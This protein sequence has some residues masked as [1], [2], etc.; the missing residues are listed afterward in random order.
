MKFSRNDYC[1]CGSGKKYKN[2]HWGQEVPVMSKKETLPAL[3]LDLD[4]LDPAKVDVMAPGYWEKLSKQLPPGMRKEFGPMIRQVKQYAEV[5]SQRVRIEAAAKILD[6]H[7][8]EYDLLTKDPSKLFRRAEDLFSEDRFAAMRF[9]AA[10]VQRAF[11][12]VGFPPSGPMEKEFTR[13]VDKAIRFLLDESRRDDL[14]QQLLRMLPDYTD[15]GRYLDGWLIQHNAQFVAEMSNGVV[16]P[17]LLVMFMYGMREW[18]E[19]RDREQEALFKEM[20]LDR[21]EIRRLG[22]EGLEARLRGLMDKPEK[23]AALKQF[24]AKHPELQAMTQAQCF[25]AEKAAVALLERDDAQRLCLSPDEVEPWLKVFERRVEAAPEGL[26]ALTATQPPDA[27]A[28]EMLART[29]YDVA[30]EMA[31]AVFTPARL[32]RLAAQ[33][34]EFRRGLSA[35]TEKELV[36]GIHGALAATHPGGDPADS[37]FLVSLCWTSLRAAMQAMA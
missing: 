17:F 7:R 34:H 24:L 23:S 8:G 15:A 5:E 2:C 37:H 30:T 26:A 9:R 27:T 13:I 1:P 20:G 31:V 12:A 29:L 32:D 18:E 14:V 4:D 22:Y 19:E 3:G 35:K 33:I 36:V 28:I 25:A 6:A 10:D 21:D 11:E 16:G